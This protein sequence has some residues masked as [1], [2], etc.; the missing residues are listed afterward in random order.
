MVPILS[1]PN[2][3]GDPFEP[4]GRGAKQKQRLAPRNLGFN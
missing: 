2:G 4:S 1:E 3:E